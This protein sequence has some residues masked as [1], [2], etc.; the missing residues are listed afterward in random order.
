MVIHH[1][2]MK[3]LEAHQ[4]DQGAADA[5]RSRGRRE[6]THTRHQ[7]PTEEAGLEGRA[8]EEGQ[9][10]QR[11]QWSWQNRPPERR[12]QLRQPGIA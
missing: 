6:R 11:P 4:E 1:Q 3:A 7:E 5:T 8:I 10:R 2:V 9:E 12:A